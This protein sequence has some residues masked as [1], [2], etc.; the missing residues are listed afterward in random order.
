MK[1]LRAL[2]DVG[3]IDL[4]WGE[5]VAWKGLY[6]RISEE[7]TVSSLRIEGIVEH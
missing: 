6:E 7:T 3:H 2:W 4:H 5:N 1:I